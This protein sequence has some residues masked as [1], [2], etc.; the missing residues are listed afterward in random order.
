[1][2]ESINDIDPIIELINQICIV[3]ANNSNFSARL[4]AIHN[5]N[6]L[7]FEAKNGQKWMVQRK[8]LTSIR[9]LPLKQGVV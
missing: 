4:I 2:T 1:M 5:K 9:P 3:Y 6:E 8:S 7:W